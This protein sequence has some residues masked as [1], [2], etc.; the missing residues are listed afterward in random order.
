MVEQIDMFPELCEAIQGPYC[1]RNLSKAWEWMHDKTA[2]S[3]DGGPHKESC[4][5]TRGLFH[6]W[7]DIGWHA[8]NDIHGA[9]GGHWKIGDSGNRGNN[10]D[11]VLS[12]AQKYI[13]TEDL[14]GVLWNE[15]YQ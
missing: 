15:D 3:I 12:R 8:A 9:R 6:T 1:C 14:A 10:S 5:I 2:E 11:H 13:E 7:V 4:N